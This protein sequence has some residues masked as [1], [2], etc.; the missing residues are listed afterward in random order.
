M[1]RNNW[2]EVEVETTTGSGSNPTTV[3][4]L[5]L[6]VDDVVRCTTRRQSETASYTYTYQLKMDT[7]N[8]KRVN[9][10]RKLKEMQ[11]ELQKAERELDGI[12]T[13]V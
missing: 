3:L 13:E 2:Q 11:D 6:S 4:M 8:V 10:T 9:T 1:F 12:Q 5:L 7:A